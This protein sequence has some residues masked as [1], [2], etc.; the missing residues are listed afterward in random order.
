MSEPDRESL[1]SDLARMEAQTLDLASEGVAAPPTAT[2]SRRY[3][4][5]DRLGVGGMGAV[6]VAYDAHL[7]RKVAIKVLH[8]AESAAAR[9]RFKREAVALARLKHPNVVTIFDAGVAGERPFLAMEL[10]EGTSLRGWLVAT[11]SWREIAA[12]FLAA[13]RGLLAAH[14]AGLVHRDVK[15]DNILVARD[16]SVRVADFGVVGLLD[17]SESGEGAAEPAEGGLTRPGRAPGTPRY[18]APEQARGPGA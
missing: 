17:E 4:L 11:R 14:A 7:E 3:V 9:A 18:M 8:R 12:V 13:G 10:V 5:L 15:P 1:A 6:Y 2:P 16:G